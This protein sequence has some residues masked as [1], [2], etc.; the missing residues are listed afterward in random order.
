MTMPEGSSVEWLF[1]GIQAVTNVALLKLMF[2]FHKE[3]LRVKERVNI[4]YTE[5]CE[6]H[7]I[8]YVPIEK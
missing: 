1:H 5:Y 4:M 6:K 3:W 8:P 2:S 7:D